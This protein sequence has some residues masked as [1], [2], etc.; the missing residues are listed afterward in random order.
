MYK[1][2]F[3]FGCSMTKYAWPTWADIYGIDKT[4]FYNYGKSGAGNQ[5]IATKVTEVDINEDDLVLV[6]WSNHTRLDSYKESWI[7]PGNIYTQDTYDENIINMFSEEGFRI[8]DNAIIKLTDGYLKN[9]K[10]D[11]KFF[12]MQPFDNFKYQTLLDSVGGSWPEVPCPQKIEYVNDYH[13]DP[14]MHYNFLE[15]VGLEPSI[16]MYEFAK[17]WQEKV[18][19]YDTHDGLEWNNEY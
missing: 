14:M 6:M 10:C 7:T 18:D 8:R 19:K 15:Y 1:R 13:P 9:L 12:L 17:K 4:N 11:Y 5:Y 2:I 16:E 3:A